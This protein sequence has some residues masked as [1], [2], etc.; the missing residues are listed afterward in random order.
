MPSRP[1]GGLRTPRRLPARGAYTDEPKAPEAP[2]PAYGHRQD[3]RD[4][5]TQGL[6][7]LGGSGDGGLPR[8]VGM[9]DGNRRDRVETP[10]ALQEGRA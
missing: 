5:L 2:R 3:G 1:H 9:R 8:R 4:E 10:R 6:F 7:S